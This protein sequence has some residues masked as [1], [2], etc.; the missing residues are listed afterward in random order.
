[1][2][3]AVMLGSSAAA[4]MATPVASSRVQS[5]GAIGKRGVRLESSMR[6][7]M[8]AVPGPRRGFELMKVCVGE[9]GLA[10][11][12]VKKTGRGIKAES[13]PQNP[14]GSPLL[15]LC[16][17]ICSGPLL[18]KIGFTPEMVGQRIDEWLALGVK[19]SRQLKFD[20]SALSQSEK[21][22]IYHYYVPVFLWC[23]RELETH[24]SKFKLGEPVPALMIGISAPQGC[25]KTTI[26]YSLEYLFNS[27]GSRA[28]SISID[29]FYLTAA[30][31]KKLSASNPGNKLLEMRSNAGSHDLKLGTET[32][33]ALRCLTTSGKEV[34]LPRYNKSANAGLGDRADPSQWS[35]IEG[36][37]KVVLFEG[38]MLGFEPQKESVVTAVDPQLV[39]VNKQLAAYYD[40]WH[41]MIDSWIVIQVDDPNWVFRWRLQVTDVYPRSGGDCNESGWKGRNDRRAGGRFCFKTDARVQSLL[42]SP[43]WPGAK[44]CSKQAHVNTSY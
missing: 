35:K 10:G 34:K 28:A 29:D 44:G 43:L 2:E 25:G 7:R 17:F 5:V 19:L 30:E 13:E 23:K 24:T 15:N 11:G 33:K 39:P 36:P 8:V 41:K 42:A 20:E 37:V 6:G 31:Q 14:P 21:V 12:V 26:V 27:L 22:R 9:L 4:S 38:W 18:M 16:D 3:E 1:M 40:A 32:L